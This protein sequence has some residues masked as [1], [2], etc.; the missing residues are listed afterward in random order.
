[1]T[2]RMPPPVAAIIIAALESS[3]LVIA[4][5]QTATEAAA[6]AETQTKLMAPWPQGDK[7]EKTW[8]PF[9]PGA[10]HGVSGALILHTKKMRNYE[11]EIGAPRSLD[12]DFREKQNITFTVAIHSGRLVFRD[13]KIK[14]R[15]LESSLSDVT[16]QCAAQ[17][18]M[19]DLEAP[20][21]VQLTKPQTVR[22]IL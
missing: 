1:M 9:I 11:R 5:M 12:R 20:W 13:P 17:V 15:Y 14:R 2:A 10:P 3:Q 7:I 4:G 8:T 19:D 16:R 22:G 21:K 6:V 18:Y